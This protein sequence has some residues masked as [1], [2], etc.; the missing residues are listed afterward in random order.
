MRHSEFA[1]L[2]QNRIHFDRKINAMIFLH[3]GFIRIIS[4][5]MRKQFLHGQVISCYII[6]VRMLW[7]QYGN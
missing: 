3:V 6:F 5:K 7:F 1:W 4:K 2:K